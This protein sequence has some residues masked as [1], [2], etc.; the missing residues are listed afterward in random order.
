MVKRQKNNQEIGRRIKFYRLKCGLTQQQMAAKLGIAQ[1][2]ISD[3]EAGKVAIPIDL[4][5]YMADFMNV[6]IAVLDDSLLKIP[7]FRDGFS[8]SKL[9]QNDEKKD[10]ELIESF[11]RRVL[12]TIMDS[13]LDANSKTKTYQII[14]NLP[15]T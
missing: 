11:R 13:D 8:E 2:Q 3:Y 1:G 5:G 10:R 15:E 12:D 7:F 6:S 14:K 4:M 9:L